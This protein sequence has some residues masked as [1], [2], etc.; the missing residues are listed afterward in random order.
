[1]GSTLDSQVDILSLCL[2]PPVH[3]K[4]GCP[5]LLTQQ[6]VQDQGL[7]DLRAKRPDICVCHRKPAILCRGVLHPT[8]Q[9]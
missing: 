4:V 3:T 9:S 8:K 7:V 6:I 1:M 5:L 2:M